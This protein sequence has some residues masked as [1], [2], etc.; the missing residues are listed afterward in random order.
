V[1]RK[2]FQDMSCSVAQCLEVIGEW[3]TMLIV[4]DAFLGVRRFDDFKSRLGI[5]RNV[6]AQRL[7]TLV[8][9]GVLEKRLYQERPPRHEYALTEKGHDLWPVLNAMRQWGDRHAAPAGPPVV[10][11]H[12]ACGHKAEMVLACAHCGDRVTHRDVRARRGP[13]GADPLPPPRRG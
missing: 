7:G 8:S 3:W 9:A 2:S 6:L 5:S 13:G 12:R 11:I 4:R 1:E 10:L